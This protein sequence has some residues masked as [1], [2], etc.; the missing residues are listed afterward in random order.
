MEDEIIPNKFVLYQNY[1]NPFN[2]T[3]TIKYSIP[4]GDANFASTTNTILKVYD[5]LGKEVLTLVDEHKSSGTYE[6]VFDASNLASGTYIYRLQ[7]GSY[8]E[9]KKMLLVK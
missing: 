5:I 3:T 2:P 1:P 8:A 4:V 7:V 6:V 9:T